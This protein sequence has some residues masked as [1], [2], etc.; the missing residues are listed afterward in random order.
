MVTSASTFIITMCLPAAIVASATSAPTF[1][2]P[3]ASMIDVDA[4][5]G[6][7]VVVRRAHRE[8]AARNGA[9][10]A[11]SPS[12]SSGSSAPVAGDCARGEH[13]VGHRVCGGHDLD[14]G[15]ESGLDDD[16]G[17]HLAGADQADAH[18]PPCRSGGFSASAMESP[19][20]ASTGLGM[21]PRF[22]RRSGDRSE[23]PDIC[24]GERTYLQP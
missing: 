15:H 11:A 3:V 5:G 21:A 22:V 19:S 9:A 24:I 18:R 20:A 2:L 1:G 17:A 16:V 4:L 12:T 14:A 23:R 10:T 7:H 8:L 6:A 13:V